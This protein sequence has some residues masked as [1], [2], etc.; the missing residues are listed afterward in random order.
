MGQPNLNM[1]QHN[2]LDVVK[3]YDYVILCHLGK[4][5]AVV[6]ALSLKATTTQVINLCLRMN[7]VPQVLE[8]IKGSWQS[9]RRTEKTRG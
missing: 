3:N 9:R 1:R 4:A 5:N 2:W 8:L 7:I 6:D